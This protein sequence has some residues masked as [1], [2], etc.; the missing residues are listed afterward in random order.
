MPFA[1]AK[2][3]YFAGAVSEI[4]ARLQRGFRPR[5]AAGKQDFAATLR[6]H[7]A[8]HSRIEAEVKFEVEE[9][10]AT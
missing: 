10:P 5:F 2:P 1:R 8:S 3:G 7:V 4:N 9:W 6:V